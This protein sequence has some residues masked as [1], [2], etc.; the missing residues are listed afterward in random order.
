MLAIEGLVSAAL[1]FTAA[2]VLGSL[3]TAAFVLPP[4]ESP[5][6]KQLISFAAMFTAAFLLIA[7]AALIVQGAK[8]SGGGLPSLDVL[9]RYVMKTQSGNVWLW[10]EI[11]GALL[12]ALLIS[13]QNTDISERAGRWMVLAAIPLA[14]SRSLTSHA[15]AAREYPLM[16]MA[17]DAI[18]LTVAAVWA[19]GLP[20]LCWALWRGSRF[21][22]SPGWTGNLVARFSRLA[23]RSVVLLVSTGI[24]QSWIQVGTWDSLLETAYGR[25]LL[26][27]L[28]LF[29]MMLAFGALNRHFTLPDLIAAPHPAPFPRDAF[30]R[31]GAEAVLAIIVFVAT[32]FL[33]ILPPG[34]HSAH[35]LAA[36][37]RFGV[38]TP[39][40][41]AAIKILSP[42]DGETLHGDEVPLKFRLTPGRRGTHAHAYVDGELMG[43]F[44]TESGTLTGITPGHHALEL[45]VVAGDHQTELDASDTVH[46][47]VK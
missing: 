27:K 32:G 44:E 8:L 26:L 1:Y 35:Q 23:F 37:P 9:L 10:R 18:H 15:A 17:C 4:G 14:A 42:R 3:A 25:V 34:A 33:T 31:I 30:Q 20:L 2:L 12:L 39:A 40:E 13:F 28:A 5:L 38:L 11:Y 7:A 36:A 43:M 29:L 47:V 6:R 16:A 22:T 45:R 19:G 24:F 21:A 41:G 46:F